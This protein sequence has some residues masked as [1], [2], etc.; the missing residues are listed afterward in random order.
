MYFF[1]S[2][3]RPRCDNK[4]WKCNSETWKGHLCMERTPLLSHYRCYSSTHY[5]KAY[6]VRQWDQTSTRPS[7]F[8]SSSL[9]TLPSWRITH[10]TKESRVK[11]V[12]LPSP[13]QPWITSHFTCLRCH[14]T[15][16]NFRQHTGRRGY[17]LIELWFS[18]NIIKCQNLTLI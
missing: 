18:Y 13:A 10:S 7:T 5:V 15:I 16:H 6:I 2:W 11:R 9:P 1:I 14:K 4:Q 3:N 17:Y 8:S 12:A